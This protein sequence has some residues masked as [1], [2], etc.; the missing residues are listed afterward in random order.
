MVGFV[1]EFF[2]LVVYTV[3]LVQPAANR[4][5][6]PL[7]VERVL[8]EIQRSSHLE[9]S[10]CAPE[11]QASVINT[12]VRIFKVAEVFITSVLSDY[13][14]W[15]PNLRIISGQAPNVFDTAKIVLIPRE[16]WIVPPLPEIGLKNDSAIL[17]VHLHYP[18]QF[19]LHVHN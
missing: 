15:K 2:K 16:S 1:E 6:N 12:E 5:I 18:H 19:K 14:V 7:V 10:D 17:L 3:I 9:F 13:G 4:D 8:S 11:V